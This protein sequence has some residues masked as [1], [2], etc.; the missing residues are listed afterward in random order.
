MQFTKHITGKCKVGLVFDHGF[1]SLAKSEDMDIFIFSDLRRGYS[2]G[3][4]E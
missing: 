3:I 1:R 2:N 4:Q